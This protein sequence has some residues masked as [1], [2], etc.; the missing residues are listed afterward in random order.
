MPESDESKFRYAARVLGHWWRG[1]CDRARPA[2]TA[3]MSRAR[4]LVER[5]WPYVR[6]MLRK[7]LPYLRAWARAVWRH[8][9]PVLHGINNSWH[10]YRLDRSR[11]RKGEERLF[12]SE[13]R[14]GG[15]LFGTRTRVDVGYWTGKRRVWAYLEENDLLLFA[16]G[17]RP[18]SERIAR[19]ELR[20]SRYNHVTGQVVLAPA[21]DAENV[22]LRMAPY[23]GYDILRR[24]SDKEDDD[25]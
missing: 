13:S 22:Q 16:Y 3:A 4:S 24:I 11:L 9:Y 25:A 18:Y 14:E 6:P 2:I 20:E 10:E 5:T 19:R 1:A 8:V 7:V 12:R 21:V 15:T 17:R 23:E